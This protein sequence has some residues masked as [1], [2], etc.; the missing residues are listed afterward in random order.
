MVEN[1]F[2]TEKC[3]IWSLG[4]I[5]YEILESRPVFTGSNPLMLARDICNCNYER[6]DKQKYKYLGKFGEKLITLV[7]LCMEVDIEQ[8]P[9]S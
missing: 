4:C 5:I 7:Q 3:D 9:S 1:R 8:R 6:L 2:Y